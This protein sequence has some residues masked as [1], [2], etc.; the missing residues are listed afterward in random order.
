M[1]WLQALKSST[2][3]RG[4]T[5]GQPGVD[6]GSFWVQPGSELESTWVQARVNLGSTWGQPGVNLRRPTSGVLNC[7]GELMYPEKPSSGRLVCPRFRAWPLN[8]FSSQRKHFPGIIASGFSDKT[9]QVELLRE[10]GAR[11]RRRIRQVRRVTMGLYKQSGCAEK[12][13]NCQAREEDAASV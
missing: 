10:Q 8:L 4:S 5:R 7:R 6:E 9:A 3:N 12:G 11:P 1:F 13:K 2:V